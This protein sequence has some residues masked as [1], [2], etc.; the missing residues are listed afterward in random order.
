M[1]KL[2]SAILYCVQVCVCVCVCCIYTNTHTHTMY[3]HLNALDVPVMIFPP[4]VVVFTG[5][6]THTHTHTEC[7]DMDCAKFM[8]NGIIQPQNTEHLKPK[9]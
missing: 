8:E 1:L 6:F 4:L 2:F 9:V 7:T 5:L 3:A